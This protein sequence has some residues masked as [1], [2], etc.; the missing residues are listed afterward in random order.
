MKVTEVQ[1]CPFVHRVPAMVQLAVD[2]LATPDGHTASFRPSSVLSSRRQLE[3]FLYVRPG[4]SS[5]SG[6]SSRRRSWQPWC[7][8]RWTS[9][10]QGMSP[11]L[12]DRVR[13]GEA[14]TREKERKGH[15][16]VVIWQQ[17]Q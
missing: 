17:P 16:V 5:R 11:L 15:D 9:F 14:R 6:R 4:S 12:K 8:C 2:E 3:R 10:R 13:R 1:S 7:R